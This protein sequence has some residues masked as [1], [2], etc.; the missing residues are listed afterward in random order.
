MSTSTYGSKSTPFSLRVMRSVF[1]VLDRL[2]S[3]LAG[4]VALEVFCIPLKRSKA[5]F[6]GVGLGAPVVEDVPFR[7]GTLRT[8][9]W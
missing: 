5:D 8:Y 7:G 3:D 4:R 2:S 9:A 1:G 6:S